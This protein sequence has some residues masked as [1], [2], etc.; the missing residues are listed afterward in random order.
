MAWPSSGEALVTETGVVGYRELGALVD[1]AAGEME[2][3]GARPGDPILLC[4]P[5]GVGWV[6]AYLAIRRIGA[7]S[8]PLNPASAPDEIGWVLDDCGASLAL[9]PAPAIPPLRAGRRVVWWP[10]GR[11]TGERANPTRP[12]LYGV[13]TIA[14][15]S[16]T[17]GRPKG[18]LQSPAAVAAGGRVPA[19]RLGL[20]AQEVVATALPL[21]H[22]F[23]TN[24]LNAVFEAGATLALLRRFDEAGIFGLV[25]EREARVIAGVPTMYRRL[26]THPGALDNLRCVLSAGQSASAALALD[27][28]RRTGG[29]FVEGWGMTEL[30]GFAAIGHPGL[31]G[32]HGTVGTTAPG[33]DLRVANGELQVRGAAVTKGYLGDPD[34]TAEAF[35]DGGWLRTGDVGEIDAAGRVTIAGRIKDVIVTG[36][37]NVYPAEVE[38]AVSAHPA[39]RDVAV[40]GLPDDQRGEIV[41]AWVVPHPEHAVTGEQ[42][43]EHCREFLASYKLP[44]RTV[45]V[46]RLPLTGTGKIARAL[47]P[48][49]VS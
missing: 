21:A 31:E 4:L 46:D 34:K 14:Y 29:A 33:I 24:V 48:G 32:R 42:L 49:L 12:S 10:D 3:A 47:L 6:A 40:A 23:G 26:L 8:V 17:T 30:A 38:R 11:P 20:G 37:Y 1:Q 44:R 22:S 15:T 36:G 43:A 27:W 18:A 7:V 19:Q 2:R 39:V 41:C 5:N 16:G 25:N 45:L 35:T 13:T 9:A 28:E